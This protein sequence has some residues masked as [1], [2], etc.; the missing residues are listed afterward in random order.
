MRDDGVETG[1]TLFGPCGERGVSEFTGVAILVA[2]TIVATA[3][4]GLS[5]LVV[6]QTAGDSVDANFSFQHI[7]GRLIVTFARGGPVEAG[8]LTVRGPESQATWAALA[9]TDPAT[10][11]SP[12]NTSIVQLSNRNAYG[13]RVDQDDNI[14][15]LYTPSVGNETLLQRWGGA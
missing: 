12:T 5:V 2:V 9:D 15:I 10:P 3:S 4:V 6:D 8:N 11:V 14:R 7:D 1:D 13:Q